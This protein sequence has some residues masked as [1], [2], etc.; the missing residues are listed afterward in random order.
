MLVAPVIPGL[1]DHEM[2]AV[3]SA[4]K[5]AG[6]VCASTELL[7]L[8]FAVA[9]MFEAWLDRN[10]PEKKEKVLNRIRAMRGGKLYDSRFGTR[11]R[12]EG[13]FA[14]QIAQMFQVARRKVG[15]PE[16]G[17]DLSTAAFRR[18]AGAQLRLL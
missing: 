11:M 2:P 13:I 14:D 16:D 12:G 7:R 1:N 18:P 8:P 4:A 10:Y 6:A 3:L 17:P 5:T 9:P 15:L